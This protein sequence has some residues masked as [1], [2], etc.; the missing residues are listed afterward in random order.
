MADVITTNIDSVVKSLSA[1]QRVDLPKAARRTVNRLGFKLARKDLPGYMRAV[2]DNPN[3]FTQRSLTYKVVSNYE[4]QLTFKQNVP[5]G[6]DPARYLYPVTKGLP[7]NKAYQ[8][9]FTRFVHKAGIVSRNRHPV[10]LKQNLS[11][12]SYGKVSQG[13]YS[14]VWSG[15]LRTKGAGKTGRGFRYFSIPDDRNR[16]GIKTRQGSLFDLPD[17]IYRVKGRG[18]DGVQ[19]LFTYARKH[20]TVPKIFDYYGYVRKYV[21]AFVP[22]ELRRHLR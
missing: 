2:F 18:A 10:P 7:D 5:K 16:P 1:F 9:K 11:K 17:G 22:R 13:E 8:T 12:N 20:P 4:V 21:P 14:K 6:N 15:L 19:L 3:K